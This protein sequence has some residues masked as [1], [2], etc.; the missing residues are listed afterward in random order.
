MGEMRTDTTFQLENLRGRQHLGGL[1]VDEKIILNW[2]LK[3]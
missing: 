3:K 2:I 1:Y